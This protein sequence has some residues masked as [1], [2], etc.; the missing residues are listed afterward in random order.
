MNR[1]KLY[2]KKDNQ[3][4]FYGCGDME[5]I[6]ELLHDYLVVNDAYGCYDKEFKIERI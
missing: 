3:F 5:Y 4:V 2:I 1:F 6:M